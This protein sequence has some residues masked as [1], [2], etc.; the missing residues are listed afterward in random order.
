MKEHRQAF[1]VML[2]EEV[3]LKEAFRYPVTL[4]PLSLAFPDSTHRQNPKQHFR[5]YLINVSKAR[6]SAHPKPPKRSPLWILRQL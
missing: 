5:N 6:E 1:E 3:N 4:V 2:G